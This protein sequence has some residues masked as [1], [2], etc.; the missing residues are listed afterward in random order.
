MSW[1]NHVTD[2]LSELNKAKL[3]ADI[4]QVLQLALQKINLITANTILSIREKEIL[5]RE[6][7]IEAQCALQNIE[8]QRR[9]V[10]LVDVL[11]LISKALS[12]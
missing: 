4:H 5:Q 2:V 12:R 11:N 6:V 1:A 10:A 8:A 3:D 7:I 9:S